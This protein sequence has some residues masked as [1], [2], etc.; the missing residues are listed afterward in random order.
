MILAMD[1]VQTSG[2]SC[3]A[4]AKMYGVAHSTLSTRVNGHVAIHDR[5][6]ATYKLT[7]LE[8]EVIVRYILDLDE[9]GFAPRL[10]GIEDIAN[11]LLEARGAELVGKN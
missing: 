5:R 6:P 9:R 8:E 7:E 3:R 2:L 1:A 11:Y 10:A 4:A